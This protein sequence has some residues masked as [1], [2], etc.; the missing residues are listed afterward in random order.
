M[1][2]SPPGRTRGHS[3]NRVKRLVKLA[4]RLHNMR[5]LDAMAAAKRKRVALETNEIYAPIAHRLGLNLVYRELQDLSFKHSSPFRYATLDK[6]IKKARG[7][8]K[9]GRTPW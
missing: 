6:A 9:S 4:D 7:K 8:I 1:T 5:T 2:Y 3:Q